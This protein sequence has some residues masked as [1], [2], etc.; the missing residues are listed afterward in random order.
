V[1]LPAV[2]T[3][4]DEQMRR[5]P[6]AGPGVRV[7]SEERVTRTI[8]TD[9]SW[10]AVVWS[11]L[12]EADA[13]ETIA[14]ELARASNSLEWKLYSHDRPV[15]LPERLKAAGLRPDAVE[16]LLV[17]E[18]ADLDLPVAE[19]PGVRVAGVDDPAG[20]QAMLR[21]SDEVFGPGSGYAWVAK[22]VREALTMKPKPIE[23]VVAWAGDEPVSAGRVEFHEGTDFASLWGGGTT[24]AWRGRGVFRALVGFR[25]QL[26]RDRGFRYLQVDALPASRLILERMGFHPLAETTPWLSPRGC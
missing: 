10:S 3:A 7:E 17:A 11:D 25:A 18:I 24:P 16:T 5:H 19:P 9:G 26:A 14:A 6:V 12:T 15:D 1:D 8:G 23:A 20:V 2:L 22:A 13:D 21:V 4:F